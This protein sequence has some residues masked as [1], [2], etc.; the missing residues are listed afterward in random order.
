MNL[1]AIIEKIGLDEE[2]SALVVKQFEEFAVI[3]AEWETKAKAIVV[4]D[5]SQTE[6]MA[7]ARS[8][9]L[10]LKN[11]RVEMEKIRKSLKDRSLKEGQ[12][13]DGIARYI[14]G[15]IE[16]IENHLDQQEKFV[17]IRE[18]QR[19][20][21]RFQSRDTVLADIGVIDRSV[22]NLREMSDDEFASLVEQTKETNRLK[23]EE[24]ARLE[25]ERIAKEK[26][27][28]EERERVRKENEV[29]RRE[30]EER[31]RELAKV[32]QEK[33]AAEVR[34]KQATESK[35]QTVLTVTEQL[36][37][38][39][40]TLTAVHQSTSSDCKECIAIRELIKSAIDKIGGWLQ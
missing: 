34:E 38:A 30:A 3:A 31:E 27:E 16:P 9:R 5:E 1:P 25:T 19:K 6:V 15:L 40:R 29:L 4:T 33:E 36:I 2:Q 18:E 17:E 10:F 24:A 12:A 11:K 13:I 8:G 35:A 20:A 37:V 14:K 22:F 32:R 26:A 39:R 7:Q 28:A 23:A 21:K